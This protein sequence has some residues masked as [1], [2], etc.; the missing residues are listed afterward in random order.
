[1]SESGIQPGTLVR[2]DRFG[3]GRVEAVDGNPLILF[4]DNRE[5]G[6]SAKLEKMPEGLLTCLPPDSPEALLW[7][8]PEELASWAEEAPLKL[9][10]LVLS[11]KGGKEKLA[12]VKKVLEVVPGCKSSTWW[13]PNQAKL[14]LPEMEGHFEVRKTEVALRSNFAEVPPDADLL[15]FLQSK[16][17]DWLFED[18]SVPVIWEEWP[19]KESFDALDKA[20]AR[21]RSGESE[22]PLRNTLQGVQGFLQ[23][24]RKKTPKAALNWLET[25]SRIH[26]K[27]DDG[28]GIHDDLTVDT[29]EVLLELCQIAGYNKSGQ[30]LLQAYTLL[31]MPDTWRQGFAAGMWTASSGPAANVAAR[32]RLFNSVSSLMG[33]QG[34][35][36]LTRE[37]ALAAFRADD[38]TRYYPEPSEIDRILSELTSS[39]EAQRLLELIALSSDASLQDKD[40]LLRYVA[41]SRHSNGPDRLNLLVLATLLLTDGQGPVAEQTSQELAAAFSMLD[42]YDPAVQA[43]FQDTKSQ[44]EEERARIA[45]EMEEMSHTHSNEIKDLQGTVRLRNQELDRQLEKRQE[46]EAQLERTRKN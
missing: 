6:D 20:I 38:A 2:H 30:W 23:P 19:V 16:W 17:R 7:D 13:S 32:R 33:R 11:I 1:M 40:K 45:R 44:I 27:R 15:S 18:P 28:A 46:L 22:Q 31:G 41:D 5:S 29:G 10:A 37:I 14:K 36:D 25:L 9:I 26:L 42:G 12:N 35:V 43:L 24:K 3:V 39:E 4:W 8:H 34:R 21:L